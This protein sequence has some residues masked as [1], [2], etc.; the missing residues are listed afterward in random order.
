MEGKTSQTSMRQLT[1][2]IPVNKLPSSIESCAANRHLRQI[3]PG[4]IT[5]KWYFVLRQVWF[6]SRSIPYQLGGVRCMLI[7][8]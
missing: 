2:V 5:K 8:S 4:V 1:E 3:I 6:T 7:R